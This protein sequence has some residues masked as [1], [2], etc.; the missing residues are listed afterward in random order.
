M[1]SVGQLLAF[2]AASVVIIVIPGPSVMFIVGRA[3][4]YGRKTALATVAGN[5]LGEFA[6]AAFVAVGLGA[7]V[8]QSALVFNVVKYAGAAYL[9]YL[10]VKAIR[11]RGRLLEDPGAGRSDSKSVLEGFL[12]GMLNPKSVLFFLAMLPQ[13]VNP[14]GASPVVQML[15]LGLIYMTLGL[16]CD[17]FTGL[18]ASTVR[19]WFES[20]RATRVL[21]GI[22][23]ASMI[24]LG[25]AAAAGERA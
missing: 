16:V 2:S 12:V 18:L 15:V 19:A 21:G 24:G 20:P 13:F 22:G 14:A 10:G 8:Q 11:D 1:P 7:V 5:N 6:A 4:A 9:I 23:G 25:A 17:S 3:L